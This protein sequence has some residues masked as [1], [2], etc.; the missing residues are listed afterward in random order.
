MR[1]VIIELQMGVSFPSV[2]CGVK[3]AY[4]QSAG[5]TVFTPFG[6]CL[7]R[8]LSARVMKTLIPLFNFV[9][10]VCYACSVVCLKFAFHLPWRLNGIYF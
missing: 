7:F 9:N 8:L 5:E 10:N 4:L 2:F 3:C 6:F 1:C